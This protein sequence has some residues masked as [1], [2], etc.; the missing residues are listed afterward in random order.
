[1]QHVWGESGDA[2]R[3]LVRKFEGKRPPAGPK[4]RWENNIKMPL[5]EVA[6]TGLFCFWKGTHR[7]LL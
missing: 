2:Y 3:V 5:Q 7:G 6:L 4:R 1:M